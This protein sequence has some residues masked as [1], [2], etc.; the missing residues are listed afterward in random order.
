MGDHG[1]NGWSHG[2]RQ[3]TAKFEKMASLAIS[4]EAIV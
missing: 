1:N 2:Q 4:G 3:K